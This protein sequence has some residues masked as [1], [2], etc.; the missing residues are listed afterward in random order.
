MMA[1]LPTH[2]YVIRPHWVN[3]FNQPAHFNHPTRTIVLLAH[4]GSMAHIWIVN[5][6]IIG[7]VNG[8]VPIRLQAVSWTNADSLSIWPWIIECSKTWIKINFKNVI[9]INARVFARSSNGNGRP[10]HNTKFS[11]TPRLQRHVCKRETMLWI[12]GCLSWLLWR[13]TTTL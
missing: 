11:T 5:S 6:V 2:I 9:Q 4:W 3:T 10:H 8:L 13:K 12:M 7:T 1:R